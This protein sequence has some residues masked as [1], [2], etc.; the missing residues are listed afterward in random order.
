MLYIYKNGHKISIINNLDIVSY[1]NSAVFKV[2]RHTLNV[3]WSVPHP[4]FSSRN[5][6]PVNVCTKDPST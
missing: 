3:I 5:V 2:V 6:V 4:T 1:I